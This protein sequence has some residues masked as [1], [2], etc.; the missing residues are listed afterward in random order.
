MFNNIKSDFEKNKRLRSTRQPQSPRSFH[1]LNFT[2]VFLKV[3]DDSARGLTL[4]KNTSSCRVKGEQ[5]GFFS[6]PF[7]SLQISFQQAVQRE[8]DDVV[9]VLELEESKDRDRK[10]L[11]GCSRG[12]NQGQ[13]C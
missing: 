3:T 1:W 2:Y 7:D 6:Y 12:L 4:C 13:R 5:D 11:I 8:G 9:H 10:E